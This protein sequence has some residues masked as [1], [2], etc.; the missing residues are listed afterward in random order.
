[1]LF[2]SYYF[3][4]VFLP[5]SLIGY[6]FAGMIGA[7]AAAA[8][9]TLCSL[10]FYALWNLNFVP[11]LLL[12]IAF[13]FALGQ[14]LLHP[15]KNHG[16]SPGTWLAVGV[17]G[18][19]LP[20]VY[21]KY[22]GAMTAFFTAADSWSAASLYLILPLGISFFTFT[23]IGYLVDCHQGQ[24]KDLDIIR[25]A[26]FV[27]FFPHLAAGPLLH[28]REIAPQLLQPSTYRLKSENLAFG[29]TYF[30]LGLSKKIMLADPLARFVGLSFAHPEASAFLSSWLGV[31]AFTF[32]LYFDFS[33]YSD[34]A[35][36]LA[37]MFGVKFPLNFDSPFKAKSII[38]FWQRWHMTLTRYLTLLLYNPIGL[39]VTR[40]RIA[41]GLPLFR[42]NSATFGAFS[43]T[44]AA[45]MFLTMT[46]AGVWHGAGLQFL[47][48][49]ALHA[50]Y[51][52]I[53]HAWQV[54]GPSFRSTTAAAKS[55][56]G[57]AGLLLT[58]GAVL[59]ANVFFRASSIDDALL[60]FKSMLGLNGLTSPLDAAAPSNFEFAFCFFI[61]WALPN[62]QQIMRAFGT[63]T[64]LERPARP[65]PLACS[66]VA[67][68]LLACDLLL[69]QDSRVFLYFQF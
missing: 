11:L 29:A 44:V 59:I 64:E 27:S 60:L 36:G 1:M 49:G 17:I 45:P 7:T 43:S 63:P 46:L 37:A 42:R 8:W 30:V 61:V 26:L 15:E 13:N 53:N 31:I 57:A 23:Q 33:G 55:A 3:I 4:I 39:W 21:F 34:M 52:T 19:L 67:G 41:K 62:T 14:V 25:Y 16:L 54:F 6:H 40:R 12:S 48:F 56:S 32:Q 38:D 24:G 35:V 20:L 47:V 50:G 51:L 10:S 22:L 69:L 18:N 9:L 66:C 28:V 5:L 65:L 58:F 2:N 68:A